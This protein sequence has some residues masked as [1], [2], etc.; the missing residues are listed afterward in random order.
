MATTKLT[1][2]Q[3]NFQGAAAFTGSNGAANGI[4]FDNGAGLV[5]SA[6][7]VYLGQAPADN[8]EAA[9]KAYVDSVAG[10]GVTANQI[11]FGNSDG[12]GVSS[13]GGLVYNPNT[14]IVGVSGSIM[15]GAGTTANFIYGSQT[16][17][18][19][20]SG[21]KVDVT[22]AAGVAVASTTFDVNA[23]GNVTVDSSAGTISIGAD[24]VDQNIN[25]G[26][27]GTRTITIGEAADS[28]LTLKS[29]GGTFSL[30]GTGQLVDLNSAAL[31]ID[32]TGAITIDGTSTFSI[33][34]VGASNVTTNGALT[35]SGSTGLNLKNDSGTIDMDSRQGAIDIDAATTIDIDGATGINIGKAADVAI[36]VDSAAFDLDASGAITIDGTSTVSIDGA[37]DMNF[38][39]ATGGSDA[40]DL[41]IASTGGGNSSVLLS[42]AGTGADAMSLDVSAGS[43]VIAPSLADGQT[44]KLG[45]NGAVEMVFTP[46]S[47]AGS[48]KWSLTN[49]AG[50]AS[51]AIALSAT[52]GGFALDAVQA[53]T[54]TLASAGDADD[55]T[56][57]VTGA[58]DASLLLTSAGTGADAISLTTSAGGMDL[59]VAGA[60]AGE[61]LDIVANSSVNISAAEDAADAVSISATGG[62]INITSSGATA[63]DDI[64]ITAVT[65]V[66]IEG[67]EADGNAVVINASH[68]SGQ[69]NIRIGGGT[70]FYADSG[71]N[72]F[73]ANF[74]I[75]NAGV[76]VS[77]GSAAVILPNYIHNSAVVTSGASA[78]EQY[79]TVTAGS[80][81]A[82]TTPTGGSGDIGISLM[83]GSLRV[84]GSN[85]MGQGSTNLLPESLRVYQNGLLLASGAANDYTIA[86]Y[87]FTS[88]SKVGFD[89]KLYTA[90]VV[91]DVFQVDVSAKAQG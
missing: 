66:N 53:S 78:K 10:G 57:A 13:D 81:L 25:I 43:M 14:D 45:K 26:T 39:I 83:T 76:F 38:S 11:A 29:L 55:L 51:D 89:V 37:D 19:R 18:L 23:S 54:I 58:N 90:P 75:Q 44:L 8:L 68:A 16:D 65:S 2:R 42:S 1:G 6:S 70:A 62:G 80:G 86:Q 21:S 20:L 15:F 82:D 77:S 73:H 85:F 17:G 87:T 5:L 67:Q 22:S 33:D 7:R 69:V 40:K 35:L 60:A 30:D 59:T 28:T 91:G 36:D 3:L 27:D 41:T 56:I 52:A 84:L 46:H 79:G 9:T 31:D 71:G 63:G 48:E 49:T 88:G 61:D 64:D 12:S 24:D 32:A 47:V 4:I 74:G 50:T 34:G 72:N